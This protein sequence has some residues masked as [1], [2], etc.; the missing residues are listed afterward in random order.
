MIAPRI[1]LNLHAP[2]IVLNVVCINIAAILALNLIPSEAQRS[3]CLTGKF[4]ACYVSQIIRTN[5]DA[6]LIRLLAVTAGVSS[7]NIISIGLMSCHI[8]IR[9][10]LCR[11]RSN[12][13]QCLHQSIVTIDLNIKITR[14]CRTVNGIGRSREAQVNLSSALCTR[15]SCQFNSSRSSGISTHL[16]RKLTYDEAPHICSTDGVNSYVVVTVFSN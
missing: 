16:N 6:Y 13:R 11:T 5:I 10:S 3:C 9:P 2:Y 14:Q 1:G 7:N 8:G 4:E 15:L 12:T